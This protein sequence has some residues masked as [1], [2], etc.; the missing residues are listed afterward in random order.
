MSV[1]TFFMTLVWELLYRFRRKVVTAYF[2]LRTTYVLPLTSKC[3]SLHTTLVLTADSVPLTFPLPTQG[4]Y[5]LL[6]ILAGFQQGEWAVRSNML[7]T[8]LLL[9]MLEPC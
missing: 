9:T 1:R 6:T 7:L 8:Y 3:Y 4:T 2:R 5:L